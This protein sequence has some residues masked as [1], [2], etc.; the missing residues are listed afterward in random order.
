MDKKAEAYKKYNGAAVAEM[1][2]KILPEMAGKVSDAVKG[3]DGITIYGTNGSSVSEISGNVPVLIKQTMDVV[4]E[5]T[6]VDM[7][8][9]IRANSIEARTNRNIDVDVKGVVPT[10]KKK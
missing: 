4:S 8:D 7:R 5:A 9:I 6:G 2:V 3:I 1:M 10:A